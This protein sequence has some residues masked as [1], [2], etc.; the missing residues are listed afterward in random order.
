MSQPAE[1]KK[2]SKAGLIIG[3]IAL[4]LAALA[5]VACF[6]WPGF[7]KKDDSA[8]SET[9][10]SSTAPV[11]E[12][13][14][15][16]SKETAALT[17]A[18]TTEPQPTVPA[19]TEA[20]TAEP[21]TTEPPVTE[22][23]NPFLDVIEDDPCYEEYLWAH[24]HGVVEGE[25][26][27]GDRILTRA[28]TL[29]M[30]WNAFDRPAAAQND[31]PFG[32]VYASADYYS[33]VL[34]AVHAHLVSVPE[35]GA[36]KPNDEMT[37][38]QAATILCSAVGGDGTGKPKAYLDVGSKKYYYNAVNW[39][40]A[41]GVLERYYDF[42]FRPSDPLL[43]ADFACWLAR[44]MEPELA[45]DPAIPEG[46]DFDYYGVE[47]NL[48]PH[49][50]AYFNAQT[51]EDQSITKKLK[52]TSESYESFQQADGFEAK[53]GYEWKKGVFLIDFGEADA[54]SYSYH[55]R[56]TVCD[57]Y[58]ADLFEANRSYNEDDSEYSWVIFNGEPW[59]IYVSHLE[60]ERIEGALFR[61]S[62]V[63][64]VPVGYDGLVVRIS[65]AENGSTNYY[66]SFDPANFVI[67]RFE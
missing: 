58:Y 22:P 52:V 34:W 39:G 2:K 59:K 60:T 10:S 63:V 66:E 50:V 45:L 29:S 3:L 19:T 51:K 12:P 43:R 5:A 15:T 57:S 11:T 21:T 9:L 56:A 33:A 42:S 61:V 6:V 4:L 26:L 46:D 14:P 31:M 16:A 36:F 8:P 65:D 47:V 37:R 18:P 38:D 30:L 48:H 32:D 20:P 40:C 24:A 54:N 7:L 23:V 64:Q 25:L 13:T 35:D 27:E 49:G 1:T 44:A 17:T 28:E 67:F 41:A 55:L 53:S 62:Y